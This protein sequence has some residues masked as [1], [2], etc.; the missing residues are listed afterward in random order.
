M[1]NVQYPENATA[2]LYCSTHCLSVSPCP[3]DHHALNGP[4]TAL[5]CTMAAQPTTGH[6]LTYRQLSHHQRCSVT[7][8]ASLLSQGQSEEPKTLNS[9]PPA[10]LLLCPLLNLP[11]QSGRGRRGGKV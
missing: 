10:P 6:G 2:L 11:Q 9:E 1:Y 3:K 5:Q 8:Q 4:S 7:T